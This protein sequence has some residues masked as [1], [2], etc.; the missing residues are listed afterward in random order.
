MIK[1]VLHK[2][3]VVEDLSES[4][5]F[6]ENLGFTKRT[7]FEKEDGAKA[8]LVRL[9]DFELEL[10]EIRGKDSKYYPIKDHIAFEVDSVELEL[11]R[12]QDMGCEVI[13]PLTPGNTV[14]C[15]AFVKAPDGQIYELVEMKEEK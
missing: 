5:K 7:E 1:K 3:F 14:K 4:T 13:T 12:L 10:W 8:S 2:S 6:Y 9:N 11:Q 15:Y